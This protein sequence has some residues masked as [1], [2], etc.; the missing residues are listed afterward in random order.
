MRT[1]NRIFVGDFETTVYDGQEDTQVWASGLC[2]IGTEDAKIFH[3]IN[4]TFEYICSL[5]ENCI[6]YYH[7]LAFDGSFWLSYLMVDAEFKQAVGKCE[8]LENPI[9]I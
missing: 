1:R 5:E 2:E 8:K 6:I 3:S 7:N 4:E 9:V